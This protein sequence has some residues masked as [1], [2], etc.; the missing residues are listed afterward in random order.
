MTSDNV[1][2]AFFPLYSC[3]AERAIRRLSQLHVQADDMRVAHLAQQRD[4]ASHFLVHVETTNLA[5]VQ[6]LDRDF[7]PRDLMLGDCSSR[8]QITPSPRR[9]RPAACETQS[10]HASQPT[11]S[12]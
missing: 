1:T 8:I 11:E 12:H 5:A 6:D 9:G 3:S 2:L 10:I 4:L 7:V